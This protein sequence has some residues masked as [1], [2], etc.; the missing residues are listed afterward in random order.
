MPFN[1]H[2]EV[3]TLGTRC[4]CQFSLS[5][6]SAAVYLNWRPQLSGTN[7]LQGK[8][9][10]PRLRFWPSARLIF[11]F[12][13]RFTGVFFLNPHWIRKLCVCQCSVLKHSPAALPSSLLRPCWIV[14]LYV[15]ME[16]L[17]GPMACCNV[18]D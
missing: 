5:W 13:L 18:M 3:R 4:S 12:Y 15:V 2:L 9:R 17:Y 8:P 1:T 6:A 14:F 16:G 11:D 7:C 10:G